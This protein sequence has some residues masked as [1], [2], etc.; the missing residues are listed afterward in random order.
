MNELVIPRIDGQP[1]LT[2]GT[3][4]ASP[5]RSVSFALGDTVFDFTFVTDSR[6][7]GVQLTPKLG[8]QIV[9]LRN[10]PPHGAAF[11]LTGFKVE[12]RAAVLSLA[13]FNQGMKDPHRILHYTAAYA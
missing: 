12:G 4:V 8:G 9:E 11:D 13:I 5:G 10:I 6:D 7:M 3:V 1:I 2:S